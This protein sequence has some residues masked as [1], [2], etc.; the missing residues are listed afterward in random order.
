MVAGRT[1]TRPSPSPDLWDPHAGP[2]APHCWAS[3]C[4]PAP[5]HLNSKLEEKPQGGDTELGAAQGRGTPPHTHT[6]SRVTQT[7]DGSP[8][9]CSGLGGVCATNQIT[10]KELR[11]DSSPKVGSEWGTTGVPRAP[12]GQGTEEG[13]S[14]PVGGLVGLGLWRPHLSLQA[15]LSRVSWA[16]LWVS[17]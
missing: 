1:P 3:T 17:S 2:T 5:Q 8:C 14:P 15:D 13:Q 7:R 6:S 16:P 11:G 12:G 4:I 9:R 10:H